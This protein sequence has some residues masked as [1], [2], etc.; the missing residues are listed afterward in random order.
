[1]VVEPWVNFWQKN[2]ELI[3]RGEV[4]KTAKISKSTLYEGYKIDTGF[5]ADMRFY[6]S[7]KACE[8]YLLRNGYTPIEEK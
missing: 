4:I 1:M 2:W 8:K 3:I 6:K 7:Y 5:I